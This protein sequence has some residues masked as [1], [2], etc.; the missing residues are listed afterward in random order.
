MSVTIPYVF[1]GGAGNKARAAEV[2]ANFNA[3]ASKFTEGAGGISDGDISSTAGIKGSKLS[4]VAGN[5]VAAAQL[6]DDAVDLRALKDDAT[7]GSPNAA[8]NTAQ[9]IK[10]GI[11]TGAKLV[12]GTITDALFAAGTIKKGSLNLASVVVSVGSVGAGA[13]ATVATGLNSATAFPVAI[14]AEDT[15]SFGPF[16]VPLKFRLNTGTGV[17]DLVGINAG[18]AGF[19]AF[20]VRVWYLTV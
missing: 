11:I 17:Y 4:A 3:I 14:V 10:D 12:A 1:V 2:N 5:R 7:S 15:A 16:Y 19:T 18:P 20:N 13:V 6:E 9:H 8:V